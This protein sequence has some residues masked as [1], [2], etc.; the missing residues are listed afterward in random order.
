MANT[1]RAI[2]EKTRIA[3][4]GIELLEDP[5][6]N[7]DTAFTSEE[8]HRYGLEGLLPHSVETLYIQVERVLGHLEASR[9][10]WSGTSTSSAL[11]IETKTLF[12]TVMSDPPKEMPNGLLEN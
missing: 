10:I 12:R 1:A 2:A 5:A 6:S 9:T 4:G 3:D 11:P 8:R 7:K